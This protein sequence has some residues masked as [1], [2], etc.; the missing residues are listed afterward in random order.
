MKGVPADPQRRAT[1]VMS[2]HTGPDIMPTW[3]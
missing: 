3:I 1:F 2:A